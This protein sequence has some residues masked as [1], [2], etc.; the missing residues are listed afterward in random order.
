MPPLCYCLEAGVEGAK[1][2]KKN[3]EVLVTLSGSFSPSSDSE[4]KVS[5]AA[6]SDLI[7]YVLL[8]FRFPNGQVILKG[9]KW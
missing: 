7:W 8:S 3:R 6:L 5:L 1:K 9:K 2:E 4:K